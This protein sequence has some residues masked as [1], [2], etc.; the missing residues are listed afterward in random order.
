MYIP[1]LDSSCKYYFIGEVIY[2][3]SAPKTLEEES[4]FRLKLNDWHTSDN[5]FQRQIPAVT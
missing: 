2:R 5:S 4:A 1:R 3:W